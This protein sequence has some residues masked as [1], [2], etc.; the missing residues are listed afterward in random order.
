[1]VR[2]LAKLARIMEFSVT[3]VDPILSIDELPEADRVLRVLDFSRL[4]EAERYI[5][6]ASRGQFD[7]EAVE[8]AM[9][10]SAKY[11]S[12]MA[13]RQRAEEIFRSLE[14]RGVPAE[15]LAAVRAPAGLDISAQTPAEIA[16][17]ILADVVKA[18]R[19]PPD[20]KV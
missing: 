2:A 13:N 1:M 10:A 5:V 9:R 15:K 6:V 3:I 18:R 4:G 14:V 8:Q 7:E 19:T 20:S 17:S 16:L 11:T 12:L